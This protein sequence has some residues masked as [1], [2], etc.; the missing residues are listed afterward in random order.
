ML[1]SVG[2]RP[3]RQRMSRIFRVFQNLYVKLIASAA[4]GVLLV[5]GMIANE[6]ISNGSIARSNASSRNQNSV[7]DEV[8]LAQQAYLRGQIQR[9]NITLAH[10]LPEAQKAFEDMKA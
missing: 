2:V 1:S 8:L 10:N 6:Q 3:G 7:V 4:V 5:A 9:R